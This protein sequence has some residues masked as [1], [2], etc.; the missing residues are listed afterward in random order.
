MRRVFL[1]VAIMV[2]P[3]LALAD[4]LSPLWST[5]GDWQIRVD[6]T[7]GDGCFM[8]GSYHDGTI[9]RIGLDITHKISYF[10]LGNAKWQSLKAGQA[11]DLGLRFDNGSM[12]FWHGFG[13][14]LS[15]SVFLAI[16][17]EN[18][19]VWKA[20][21][22]AS[23]LSFT[24]KGNNIATLPLTGTTAAVKKLF[25]CQSEY[26]WGQSSSDP[27]AGTS[28]PNDSSNADPFAK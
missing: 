27:F 5:S 25:Q 19:K 2:L 16:P 24:Y 8:L 7:L 6:S 9:L 23:A 26:G 14:R 12:Q 4:N 3:S 18:P 1:T 13:D 28:P 20:I 17:F 22:D 11:Y 15:G 21:S 10:M